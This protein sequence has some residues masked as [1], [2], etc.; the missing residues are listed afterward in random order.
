M[1]EENFHVYG[2]RKV[3]RQS[4]CESVSLLWWLPPLPRPTALDLKLER[5]AEGDPN[6]HDDGKYRSCLKRL[7]HGNR[8]DDVT[9]DQEF[10]T[11]D[12]GSRQVA[13]VR[14][15]SRQVFFLAEPGDVPGGG[16]KEAGDHDDHTDGF[17]GEPGYAEE[18]PDTI[19]VFARQ[20]YSGDST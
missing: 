9:S 6:D 12:N 17:E 1:F 11:E 10:Q 8:P 5:Q 3:W 13:S 15:V 16:D 18:F 19:H 2:V 4:E 20:S 14:M 7:V